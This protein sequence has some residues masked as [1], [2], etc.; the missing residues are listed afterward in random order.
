MTVSVPLLVVLLLAWRQPRGAA[1]VASSPRLEIPFDFGWRFHLGTPGNG[2][3]FCSDRGSV[4]TVQLN[5]VQCTGLSANQQA[6]TADLCEAAACA[7]RATTWQFCADSKCKAPCF[8]G[9]IPYIKQCTRPDGRFVGAGRA[10]DTWPL[11]T[12]PAAT[13]F[14]DSS[15]YIVDTPHDA[16]IATPYSNSSYNGEASIPRN[17]TWYRKHFVLPIAWS[18]SHVSVYFDGA[19]AVTHA[20]LNGVPVANH[21]C[22]YTS[23]ALRLDN[24]TGVKWGEPNVLALF[25][26]ATPYTGWWC[27]ADQ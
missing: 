8:F 9:N 20:W 10:L 7:N 26:D 19:Y 23:F 3:K 21:S 18:D 17:V 12:A 16:L 24:V 11:D 6:V 4:Y 5:D 2:S 27:V 15:F 13:N 22:G 14:N 25:V 1:A